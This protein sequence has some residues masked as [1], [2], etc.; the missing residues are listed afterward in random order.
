MGMAVGISLLSCK[1]AEIY[2]MS[3]LLPVNSRHL[4]FSTYPE[5]GQYYHFSPGCPIP[6]TWVQ[7]WNLVPRLSTSW[8]VGTS[9]LKDAILDF[10][11]P[12]KSYNIPGSSNG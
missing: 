8:D 10:S 3:F 2:V 11:L 5:I 1:E 4:R 6:K 9:D 7:P 12:V